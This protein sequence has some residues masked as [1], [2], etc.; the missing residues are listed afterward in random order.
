MSDNATP[1]ETHEPPTTLGV[2]EAIAVLVA[3]GLDGKQT[4]AA[5]LALHN[6]GIS[7]SVLAPHTDGEI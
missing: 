2:M 1:I 7:F 4:A 5:I 3:A 6:A